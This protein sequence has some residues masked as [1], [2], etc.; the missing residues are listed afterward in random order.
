MTK[1][2]YYFTLHQVWNI[3]VHNAENS[4]SGPLYFKIFLG[5]GMPPDPPRGSL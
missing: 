3:E 2:M 5:G 4:I 1:N